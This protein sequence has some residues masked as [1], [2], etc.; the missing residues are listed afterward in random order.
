MP[1]PNPANDAKLIISKPGLK[2]TKAPIN[3]KKTAIHL[4]L[5]TYSFNII[6]E[7]RVDIMG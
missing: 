7:R 2:T 3:P 6:D 1:V 5:P 4:L